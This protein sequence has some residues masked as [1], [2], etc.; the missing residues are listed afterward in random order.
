M[1]DMSKIKHLSLQTNMPQHQVL[2]EDETISSQQTL[3]D[4]IPNSSSLIED[5]DDLVNADEEVPYTFNFDPFSPLNSSFFVPFTSFFS[6]SQSVTNND[7]DD[8]DDFVSSNIEELG[9]RFQGGR[10]LRVFGIESNSNT[11]E[12]GE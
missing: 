8:N 2:E 7:H 12:S 10:G 3:D 6:L 11:E 5:G 4:S 9:F 1:A